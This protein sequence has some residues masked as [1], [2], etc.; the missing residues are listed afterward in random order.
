M[1]EIGGKSGLVE[2]VHLKTTTLRDLAGNVHYIPNGLV[3]VVTNMTKEYS[4]YVFEIGI[5]YKE[6]V[7]R[8]MGGNKGDRRGIKK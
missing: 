6:D 4:R 5:A 8:V 1:V 3:Q 7:D 2:K